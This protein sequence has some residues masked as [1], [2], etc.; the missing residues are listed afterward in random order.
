MT[1]EAPF[2]THR[3]H[4]CDS[5]KKYI[6]SLTPKFGFDSFGEVVYYRT[7]SRI[8]DNGVQ[9]SW[10]DTILRVTEGIFS[11]RKDYFIKHK[12]Q[13][14]DSDWQ[15][16]ALEFATSMFNMEY[17]APG[18]GLW[19]SGT[20]LVYNRGS[21]ALY[22]CCCADLTDFVE[23][24]SF[25]F[26]ALMNG[27][28][29]GMDV[30]WHGHAVMPNKKNTYTFV[31]PDTREGWQ[32]SLTKLLEAYLPN[33]KD[34]NPVPV[35]GTQLE[36]LPNDLIKELKNY[37][38]KFPIFDFS[39]IRKK[40]TPIKG[41]GGTASGHQPLKLMLKRTEVY[42]D[43]YI[44]YQTCKTDEERLN[45]F[46]EII[47]R[48]P[49]DYSDQ[50]E[51]KERVRKAHKGEYK[52]K[53]DKTWLSASIIN[54]VG[55]CVISGNTRR[56]SEILI[57]EPSDQTFLKLKD[58]TVH[59]ERDP[60]SWMSNNTCRMERTSDFQHTPNIAE[61][62]HQK[63]EPGIL[64]VLNIKRYGR[65]GHRLDPNDPLTR[66]M[67]PDNA[68]L[69][70]P[71]V[72]GDTL[73][74]TDRGWVKCL[75]LVGTPFVAILD[76]KEY[77]STPV[78]FWS[79]GIKKVFKLTLKNGMSV[80]CTEDH[81]IYT[82]RGKVTLQDL[83]IEEDQII[84]PDNK[85]G[86]EAS[87]IDTIEP[88]EEEQEVFDCTIYDVHAFNAGGI[89]VQ[90]CGEICLEPFEV[91][92]LAE[93][94]PTRC[95]VDGKFDEQ[96]FYKALRFATFYSS[97]VTLLPTH[98]QKTNAIVARN[99]RIGVSLSG[100]TDFLDIIG[101]T[102]LTRLL[103][104]AYKVIRQENS[105]LARE[106]GIPESLRVT[107]IKPSGSIS[108]L[109]G[110]SSGLHFP[111]FRYAI[112]RMRISDDSPLVP[113]LKASNY[114]WEWDHYSKGTLVFEFPIDQSKTRSAEEVSMW[115]QFNLLVALQ[116]EYADNMV[117][118]TITY[119]KETEGPQLEH[120]LAMNLPLVKSASVFPH[121][122]KGAYVQMPYEGITE[123]E[124][125][126]RKAQLKPID[127]SSFSGSD[128]IMPKYCTGDRC[129]L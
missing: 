7:Y 99:R 37:G 23:G 96:R 2:V 34:H 119:N 109:P 39:L 116:R 126:R 73:V 89:K 31:V 56:S 82:T 27:C 42:F 45:C 72:T 63:G 57:G 127:W 25:L 85:E 22:N 24:I 108:H 107:T 93:V 4:L 18:R 128:G 113:I 76:G 124:Y 59:P 103:R 51:Y 87:S 1:S 80:K 15:E 53:L 83:K 28:G 100:I 120:A 69:C 61:Q 52:P 78:G 91:C 97:T 62:I 79:S 66:E 98:W 105:K 68:T 110:V 106:A 32:E 21:A 94:F 47:D 8:M 70:N 10:H 65:I 84:T 114:K 104:A 40:G 101:F 46:L 5:T 71:C 26:S 49:E 16:Y 30:L 64:N 13:W 122:K 67:E 3:F 20:D 58:A 50:E 102:E 17:S 35:K 14:S 33:T 12:L 54:N 92:N 111:S 88:I 55:V 19:C 74:L 36:I 11:I 81:K 75:D 29:V 43:A 60:I 6:K 38:P 41:F 118:V 95:F 112:R 117:S 115:Q 121:S 90:N 9:E 86:T 125:K 44:K 129:E 123:E 77:N 48:I